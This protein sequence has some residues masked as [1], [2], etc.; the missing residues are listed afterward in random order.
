MRSRGRVWPQQGLRPLYR[1]TGRGEGQP[2]LREQYVECIRASDCAQ[3]LRVVLRRFS[4]VDT[5]TT[6]F[7]CTVSTLPSSYR[8]RPRE[9]EGISERLGAWLLHGG[10][11]CW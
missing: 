4:V 2:C 1:P 7:E 9:R 3:A 10:V 11:R 8:S 6:W 5:G